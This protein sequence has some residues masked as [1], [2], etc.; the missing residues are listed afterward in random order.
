MLLTR[1]PLSPGPKS[2][3][4]LDLHVLSAPP[5]FV[6]SQDQTLRERLGAPTIERSKQVSSVRARCSI[7]FQRKRRR[8]HVPSQADAHERS[9]RFTLLSFQRP[10]RLCGNK[11]PLTRTRGH[12]GENRQ[13]SYP[14]ARRLSP[15]RVTG[16]LHPPRGR[17]RDGSTVDSRVNQAVRRRFS[18]RGARSAASPPAPRRR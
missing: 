3:F 5:A 12:R 17:P 18:P 13:E 15:C 9:R 6:L 11:K 14:L 16:F 8:V 7:V 4:S 1:S 2:W 10:R